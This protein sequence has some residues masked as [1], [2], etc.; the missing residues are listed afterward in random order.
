MKRSEIYWGRL[1]PVEGSEL[2]KTRPCVIVSLDSLNA[3]LPTVV[4]CPLTTVLRPHWRTRLQVTC[5]GKKADVCADQ[6]RV[7]S[8]ARL[9]DKIGTLAVGDAAAL[10]ELLSEMYGEA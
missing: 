3:I 4:V 8:K 10:R 2:G 1:D 5:A 6:I 9:A 7:M